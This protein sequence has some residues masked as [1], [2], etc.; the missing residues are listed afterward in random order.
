MEEFFALPFFI[1]NTMQ[2]LYLFLLFAISFGNLSAQKQGYWQ[3]HVDYKMDVTMDVKNYQ[4]KG[5]Q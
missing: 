4:Y 1:L 5:I 2:K 3:Q